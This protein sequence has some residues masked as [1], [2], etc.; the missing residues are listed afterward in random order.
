[1]LLRARSLG[2]VLGLSMCIAGAMTVLAPVAEAMPVPAATACNQREDIE[3]T[4][5]G[6]SALI[7]H[8]EIE[9]QNLVAAYTLRARAFEQT[10]ELR[11]SFRDVGEALRLQPNLAPARATQIILAGTLNSRCTPWPN[12]GKSHEAIEA[13]SIIIE[14]GSVFY[15]SAAIGRARVDRGLL[16][17]AAGRLQEAM[18]D[19][20]A[21]TRPSS[22]AIAGDVARADEEIRAN[23]K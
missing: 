23:Q 2:F 16:L 14:E 13:C 5:R 21:V 15:R 9:L 3:L 12:Q 1:M 11:L 7:G 20:R 10:G 6:C 22:G 8:P 19:F 17:K 4:I 18:D